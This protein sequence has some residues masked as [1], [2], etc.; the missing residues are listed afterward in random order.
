MT[1]P[2]IDHDRTL[3]D[4][5]TVTGDEREHLAHALRGPVEPRTGVHAYRTAVQSLDT[6]SNNSTCELGVRSGK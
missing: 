1:A 2:A 5:I 6:G 4:W 3:I